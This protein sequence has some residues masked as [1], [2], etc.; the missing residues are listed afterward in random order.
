METFAV[1]TIFILLLLPEDLLGKFFGNYLQ[2]T[3]T[4]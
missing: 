2:A 1:Y 4:V 3:T